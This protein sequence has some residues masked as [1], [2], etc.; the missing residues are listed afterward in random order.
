MDRDPADAVGA[1]APAVVRNK[2]EEK[3]EPSGAAWLCR[4]CAHI[5]KKQFKYPEHPWVYCARSGCAMSPQEQQVA[6]EL[7]RARQGL[8][9]VLTGM[10]GAAKHT[11]DAEQL[12]IPEAA[13][14][15]KRS[16]KGMYRLAA[17]GHLPG[18]VKVGGK[19]TVRR[20]VLLGSSLEGRV[21]PGRTRR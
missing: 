1:E 12:T 13:A 14:L 15:L 17:A 8:E 16:V 19:W 5:L 20:S 11:E 21:S 4:S 2:T 10:S 7:A 3:G 6:L 9:S 18:A